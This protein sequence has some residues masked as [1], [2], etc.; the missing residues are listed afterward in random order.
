MDDLWIEL[1]LDE[2]ETQKNGIAFII[3]MEGI[4]WQFMRYL[5]PL[6]VKVGTRKAEV[7]T[8]NVKS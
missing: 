1:A 3:D 2:E 8:F 7:C 6:N 5:T 4:S